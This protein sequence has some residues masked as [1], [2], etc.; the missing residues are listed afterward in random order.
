V[1]PIGL[2]VSG[3][4]SGITGQFDQW[5]AVKNS[6]DYWSDRF[7]TRLTELQAGIRP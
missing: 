1:V 7:K 6:V 5:S 2:A 4:K 3:L